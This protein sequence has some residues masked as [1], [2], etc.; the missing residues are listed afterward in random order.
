MTD[1]RVHHHVEIKEGD[2]TV[3]AADVTT[4]SE[5]EGTAQ[6]SLRAAP[7]HVP[8]G[9]R[10]SLVDAVMDLPEVQESTRLEAALPLGDS[11]TLGRLRER[12]DNATTRAAGSSALVDADI[13]PGTGPDVPRAPALTP[14]RTR[15]RAG[16]R[17]LRPA[18]HGMIPAAAEFRPGMTT[19]GFIGSG[20]IGGTV[21]RLSVAAGHAVVL[22]NSR[23]PDTLKDL[24]SELGPL[25]R[26]ASGEDAADADIVLV[27]IPL[28]AYRTVPVRRLVGKTVM[29]AD[30]YY[31]QRDGQIADLDAKRLTSSELLQRHLR[32]S[33]VVKAFNN[34]YFRHLAS[35]VRPS[36]AGDRSYLPIAGDD[37]GAKAEVTAFLD[38]I[39]Y[40]AVDAGPLGE[41]W[42]QQPGEPAY[43][44]PYGPME[45]AGGRPAGEGTIRRAL[46]AA[47]R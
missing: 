3:A 47:T 10:A 34:I 2:E 20:M 7:G 15:S 41:S 36:G 4:P 16:R 38:S 12:S 39:G 33:L 24:V 1:P 45:D 23:G 14:R 29:D 21:A 32:S 37:A 31:P 18:G 43:G 9:H 28:R 27:A 26:A 42:R 40:G 6:A 25:A 5:S 17:R 46:A 30:N 8:P 35:L 44:A 11:E 22:S 19:V 13:P